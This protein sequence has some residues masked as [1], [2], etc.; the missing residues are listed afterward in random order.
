ML[1]LITPLIVFLGSLISNS[2]P[3]VGVPYLVGVGIA[4][5][6]M[7][8]RDVAITVILSALGASIGKIVVY[9][10]G[11]SFRIKL[12]EKTKKNLEIFK[13]LL[14]KSLLLATIVFAATPLP[15]DVLYIPLGV[16]GYSLPLYFLG[17]F[18]GKLILTSV[19][20]LYFGYTAK[21][22]ESI[23]M[24]NL[25]LGIAVTCLI[26]AVTAL[27]TY[28]IV[29]IDWI[30][31]ASAWRERGAIH[32]IRVLVNEFIRVTASLFSKFISSLRAFSVRT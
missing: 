9:F 8:Y 28:S 10:F 12:D 4:V 30:K 3:F 15:D 29:K 19:V 6:R 27:F 13:D 17:V 14:G 23:V 21:I 22:V 32:G 1:E 2:I 31:V 24:K 7:S 20:C 11:R 26:A 16:S 25:A 5:S 18:T